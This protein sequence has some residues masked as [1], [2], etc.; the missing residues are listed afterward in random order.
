MSRIQAEYKLTFC[1]QHYILFYP[2]KTALEYTRGQK[3]SPSRGPQVYSGAE[4]V[5]SFFVFKI[6]VVR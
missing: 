1:M 6:N 4:C 2:L 3:M 5:F